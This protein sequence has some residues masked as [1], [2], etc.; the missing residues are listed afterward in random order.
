M[1]SLPCILA[2]SL[3]FLANLPESLAFQRAMGNV[4]KTQE[5]VLQKILARHRKTDFGRR[6]RFSEL[7]SV[8]AFQDQVPLS[9]YEDYLANVERISAG[10]GKVLTADK[11]TLL[12]PTSG[13]S[14]ASKLIPFTGQLQKEFQKAIAPW[15][16]CL[17][18]TKPILFG[19]PAYWAI[20]PVVHH[21]KRTS[22][23]IPIGFEE[24]SEYFGRWRRRL[25]DRLMAVPSLVRR[26]QDIDTFFYVTLLFLLR[27]RRLRLISVWSPT[28][29]ILLMEKL[30]RFGEQLA[31]DIAYGRISSPT[32]LPAHLAA[33][34]QAL[35]QSDQRRADQIRAAIRRGGK[36]GEVHTH[37]WP[38]LRLLSCWTDATAAGFIPDLRRL[39]PNAEIQG[40]GLIAT[41]GIISFP[42]DLRSNA[43]LAL[44][45][46]FFEFVD[47]DSGRIYLAH[48]LVQGK[49]YS[50]VITT[51]G[52]LYRYKLH[53]L[54]EVT[55]HRRDCPMLR[56][57]GKEAHISDRFGEK[58]N[59]M[60][61]KNAFDHCFSRQKIAPAFAMLACEEVSGRHA[62]TLFLE[63]RN[64]GKK[65]LHHLAQNL[66]EALQENFHY[67]YCR[68]LGQLDP[69]RIYSI[70]EAGHASCLAHC[71]SLG[72]RLGDIKPMALQQFSG[73]LEVFH[74]ELLTDASGQEEM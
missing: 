27:S 25:V 37:L 30:E 3:W 35:N 63:C 34:L 45:S 68:D 1:R 38:N 47:P 43:V 42:L 59:E 2:N 74:G 11:V 17:Y 49:R 62:Y 21:E 67:R 15:L 9:I 19:G 10:E 72:Q 22:G 55:G 18:L 7:K 51:G 8:A 4:A 20:T 32:P 56:F 46:H 52:G 60:H 13:S 66:E 58:L 12:E 40:K 53:D 71:R 48:E 54:I 26:I 23:N 29:L 39:F 50:V 57:I 73:W 31:D 33:P 65:T 64:T 41:E 6:H 36:P 69:V 28:F 61:V 44:R 24:D 16:A 14:T 70:R 5:R